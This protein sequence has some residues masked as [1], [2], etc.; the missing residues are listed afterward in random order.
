M[1]ITKKFVTFSFPGSF[2]SEESTHEVQS[3]EIPAIPSD[4]FGFRFHETDYLKDG[5]EEYV[6]KTRYQD[7]VYLIGEKVHIDAIPET[8]ENR[9]LRA[10]IRNNSA[11]HEGVKTHL[12]NWQLVDENT[13]ILSP[14]EVRFTKPA[15]YE[16]FRDKSSE[17]PA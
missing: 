3:F 13:I 5:D 10:N 1:K 16:N 7:K 14:E 17:V 2:V 11:T 8:S 4:C 9:I 15:I 6:G 12:G